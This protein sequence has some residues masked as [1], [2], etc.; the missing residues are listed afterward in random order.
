MPIRFDVERAGNTQPENAN[1]KFWVGLG[2]GVATLTM[3]VALGWRFILLGV[4]V[5]IG[6]AVYFGLR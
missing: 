1:R 3:I 4:A 2:V 5:L 6:I